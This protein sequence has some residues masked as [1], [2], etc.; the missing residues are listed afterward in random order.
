MRKISKSIQEIKESLSPTK[1]KIYEYI[2]SSEIPVSIKQLKDWIGLSNVMIH[3]H[4]KK[5]LEEK[6]IQ[7][8]GSAP[9]VL[10]SAIDPEKNTSVHF[11]E[12][13]VSKNGENILLEKNWLSITPEGKRISGEKGFEYWCT[14]RGFDPDI[15]KSEYIKIF[16]QYDQF[17]KDGYIDA[18]EKFYTTFPN[19]KI[20]KKAYYLDFFSYEIFG[21]TKWGQLVLHAKLSEDPKL[22]H[23][24][25]SWAD[26]LIKKIIN[27]HNITAIGYIPHSL[28]RKTPFI[29]GLKKFLNIPLFEIPIF[30]T[31]GEITIAQKTLKKSAERVENAEKTIFISH[32]IT[33]Y[34]GNVLLIDDA[35]GSGATLQKTAEKLYK[36]GVKNIYT[37]ALVGSINGFE[38]I[39]EI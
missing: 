6:K 23:E 39:S 1:E 36:K 16:H 2:L 27:Q 5:L 3:R 17:R 34:S 13:T 35:V 28:K 7:K 11:S 24:V 33:S 4:I 20:I 22:L 18:T 31:T 38:V 25:Y 29:P 12:R 26:P 8:H 9:K 10:Y 14:K 32:D 21:R 37:L 19:Q 15:K 30:K